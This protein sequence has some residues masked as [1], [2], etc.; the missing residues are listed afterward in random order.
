MTLDLTHEIELKIHFGL[1]LMVV[2]HAVF[3]LIG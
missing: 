2:L 1:G 3:S